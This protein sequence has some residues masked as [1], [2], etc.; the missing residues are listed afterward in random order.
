MRTAPAIARNLPQIRADIRRGGVHLRH[1][2]AG[3]RILVLFAALLASEAMKKRG[4]PSIADF[5][6]IVVDDDVAVRNSL[7][8]SLAIEGFTVRAM[9]RETNCSMRAT[10]HPAIVLL[11]TKNCLA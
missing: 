8:F 10:S 11:S 4:G 7:A 1:I 5:V 3:G 2:K 6:V 9:R